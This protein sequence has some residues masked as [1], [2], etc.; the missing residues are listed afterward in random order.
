MTQIESQS[1]QIPSIGENLDVT[2]ELDSLLISLDLITP[3]PPQRLDSIN[4]PSSI[5]GNLASIAAIQSQ[6][7]FQELN[8]TRDRL[9]TAHTDLQLIHQ[10]NQAQVDV[11]DANVSE[12]KQ[13]KFQTQQLANYSKNQLE[14][15]EKMLDQIE[16]I[17]LDIFTGLEHFGGS[18]QIQLMLT[19]LETTRHDLIIARDFATTG[20]EAFYDSLNAIQLEVFTRSHESEQKL[21]QYQE[22]IQGLAQTICSDRLQIASMS[23][24]LRIK[25]TDLHGLNTQITTTHGQILETSQLMQ[26]RISEIDRKFIQLSTSI[27]T[28]TEQFYALTAATIDRA[29]LMRSQLVEIVKQIN[30]DRDTISTLKANFG[31]V[32]QTI[33]Q[34]IEQQLSN[35]YVRER[36]LIATWDDLQ[37]RSKHQIGTTKKLLTWLWILSAL[38][39]AIFILLIRVLVMLK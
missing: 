26:S 34:E 1:I 15:V 13:L 22:S 12:I 10:R 8:T 24:E 30:D 23:V 31:T 36:E 3:Q 17:Q 4:E 5:S 21:I 20:Q 11:I 37:V 2:T 9:I 7:I 39:G 32:Q 28:E 25:L 19:Q 14:K 27:N 16:Q 29:D 38:V 18:E 6:Q 35:F 33:Q